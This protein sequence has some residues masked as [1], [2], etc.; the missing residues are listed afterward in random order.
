LE[1]YIWLRYKNAKDYDSSSAKHMVNMYWC[2]TLPANRG[3]LTK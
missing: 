3:M 2:D 1:D